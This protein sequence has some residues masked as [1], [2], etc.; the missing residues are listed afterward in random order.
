L[1]DRRE[2]QPG[3]PSRLHARA[4]ELFLDLRALE[5]ARREAELVRASGGDEALVAEVRS[6]LAHDDG[7]AAEPRGLAVPPERLGPYRIVRR[8]GHGGSGQV[9]LAEQTEPIQR[10][11]AIKIVPQA[12]L[13]P[14]L[15]ARFEVERRSLERADHPGVARILDAGRT[16]DGL[17]YLVMDHVEGLPITAYC[18]ANAVPLVQRI[19]L[20]LAVAD[21]IRHAHQRGVI[22][23]DVKPANVL[24]TEVDG[25]PTPRVLDFGIAKPVA[26][27][28]DPAAPPT[29]GLPVG[30]PAYMAPEQTGV[31]E[32]DT[33]VDVYA[34][35]ALLY[36]LVAGRPPIPPRRAADAAAPD[37]LVLLERIRTEI[38]PPASRL[39]E[40][41]EAVRAPRS[42]RHD[43]DCILA[44]ALEKAPDRRYAS[45]DA[46]IDDLRRL[47]AREPI[48]ARAPTTLYRLARLVQR[49]R[50]L[51][52][53][54]S[55][56]GL[57]LVLGVLGLG[58][59]LLESDRRREEVTAQKNALADAL[60]E[61]ELAR[62]RALDQMDALA[63]VNRFLTDDLLAAAA[64]ER[65]GQEATVL[66][67]VMRA[68]DLID[69]RFPGRPLVAAGVHHALGGALAQL[70]EYERAAPHLERAVALRLRAGGPEWPDLVRSEIAAA[71]LLA[72]RERYAEAAPRLE[73]AVARAR[74]ILGRDDRDLYAALNDLGVTWESLGRLDQAEEA[75]E[76]ALD[77]RERL[78]GP[79]DP[80]VFETMANLAFVLEGRGRVDDSIDLLERALAAA[81]AMEEPPR[82]TLL[83]LHNNLGATYQDLGRDA[84]AAPHLRE[85]AAI[86]ADLLGPDHP[87]TL[88]IQGN[89]AGLEAELGDPLR[90]AELYG[91]LAAARARAVG[92]DAENTLTARYGRQDALRL[93]GRCEDAV[94]GF[95]ELLGDV[96]AA[97][98]SESFL[99]AQ[100]C[101]SLA[102]ALL[103]CGRADDALAPAEDGAAR[104]EAL[105]GPEHYRTTGSRN[106]L[107]AVRA[108]LR[109]E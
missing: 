12:A 28:F 32:V 42:F 24:V 73:A 55:L 107:A 34:L 30:T 79:N 60:R 106:V 103:D 72:R 48:V 45:V 29:S 66:E 94:T 51:A 96:E 104:M 27:R 9:F 76:E 50:A 65:E 80:D 14:E 100:T 40:R 18:E 98:G 108:A 61:T 77:G 105:Y 69:E 93:A 33:R 101:S 8:I 67:L 16:P 3:D 78:L 37:P 53:A 5:P 31:G 39:A 84:D 36:E 23:R 4:S 21:A 75:F 83:G 109:E 41:R 25:R 58:Y 62:G 19:E 86:A 35:G 87:A 88:T 43:L 11:V 99:A 59:G 64:P 1:S 97:L 102:R 82:M 95:D 49:N 71:S 47:L 92:P 15:A 57:G 52:T 13:D 74:A 7:I 46:L 81:T 68:S 54:L 22:H 63:E 91:E 26:G 20:V 85:A 89:L 10:R 2:D 17:P 56:V 90:A 70:G 6:L 44:K 38:P